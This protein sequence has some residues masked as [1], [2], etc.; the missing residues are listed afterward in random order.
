MNASETAGPIFENSTRAAAMKSSRSAQNFVAK[1]RPSE[2][3]GDSVGEG[4]ICSSSRAISWL[5]QQTSA[6]AG[7]RGL[8]VVVKDQFANRRRWYTRFA[9]GGPS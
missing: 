5:S 9:L 8:V 2:P 4:N 7:E 6:P 1:Q 3:P